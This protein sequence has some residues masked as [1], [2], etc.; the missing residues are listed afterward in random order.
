M[1]HQHLAEFYLLVWGPV[2]L[3]TMTIVAIDVFLSAL[4]EAQQH[5]F[6][7]RGMQHLWT[8]TGTCWLLCLQAS[9]AQQRHDAVG[10]GIP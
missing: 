3:A 10:S 4:L 7:A 5:P 9:M 8:Q 1:E 6:L 2:S